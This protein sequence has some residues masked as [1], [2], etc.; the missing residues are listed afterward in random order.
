MNLCSYHWIF[1]TPEVIRGVQGSN[2]E[3]LDNSQQDL[4]TEL[5]ADLFM[6]QLARD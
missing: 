6:F 5:N 4:Y 1:W 3:L 2:T